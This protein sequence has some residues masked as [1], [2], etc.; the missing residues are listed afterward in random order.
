MAVNIKLKHS[1]VDGKA[2][3]AAD[4]EN[5]EL[6]LNINENSPAAYI[7]DSNGDIVKLAGAGSVTDDDAVKKSEIASQNMVGDLTLGTDNIELDAADGSARFGAGNITITNGSNTKVFTVN[8]QDTS[9]RSQIGI[10]GASNTTQARGRITLDGVDSLSGDNLNAVVIS[11][12]NFPNQIKLKYDGSAEFVGGD[13]EIRSTGEIVTNRAGS[14]S[15][16]SI[17]RAGV[18]GLNIQ[19]DGK[20]TL[21]GVVGSAPNI[22]LN[23]D[24]SAQFGNNNVEITQGGVITGTRFK[25]TGDARDGAEIGW[26]VHTS[27]GVEV[28]RNLLN[29]DGSTGQPLIR[30]YATGNANPVFE[31]KTNG[32]IQSLSQNGGQLAGYRNQLIN[33]SFHF[34]QRYGIPVGTNQ[35]SLSNGDFVCDRW[36]LA[37]NPTANWRN[38]GRVSAVLT[39]VSTSGIGLRFNDSGDG[40]SNKRLVQAIELPNFG[41]NGQFA[42]GTTW[43]LSF[44]CDV[45]CSS[46]IPS[47][48]IFR[49]TVVD[50][51]SQVLL[52]S[53]GPAN[54]TSGQTIDGFTQYSATFTVDGDASSSAAASSIACLSVFIELPANSNSIIIAPQFEPGPVATP[55]EHL[56]MGTELALCQRYFFK[57]SGRLN[58]SKNCTNSNAGTDDQGFV[59]V[60]FPVQMRAAGTVDSSTLSL[61][62]AKDASIVQRSPQ[63]LMVFMT[64]TTT[65]PSNSCGINAGLT[66]DAE[67]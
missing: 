39:G 42:I 34:D 40:S 7:K 38:V 12:E 46:V 17:R 5:G 18:E 51:A 25:T 37:G 44:W 58:A 41:I 31:V 61:N 49:Q 66:V 19:S 4:L 47:T 26:M 45:D 57:T 53:G 22:S 64:S 6:A 60:F 36:I 24:G 23:A 1:S 14:G 27:R 2:P 20:L 32:D 35:P 8:T 29:N 30:G 43:T 48:P 59:N 63:S 15:L 65:S 55:F 28:T 56:P 54:Y 11:R 9:A 10:F 33:S 3:I 50:S 16:L 13:V 62:V 67:L 21:G 52:D